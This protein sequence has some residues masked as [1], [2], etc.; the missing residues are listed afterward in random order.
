MKQTSAALSSYQVLYKL[1][2]IEKDFAAVI[3]SNC[4]GIPKFLK[5]KPEQ[6]GHSY[7]QREVG[8]PLSNVVFIIRGKP[9]IVSSIIN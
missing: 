1:L 6:V 3:S 5:Q 4:T 2:P 8:F 7:I 9:S